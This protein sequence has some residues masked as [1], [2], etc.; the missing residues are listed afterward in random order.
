MF[1]FTHVIKR[2]YL[3]L[4]LHNGIS[5]PSWIL[6]VLTNRLDTYDPKF[7]RPAR[8]Y[9][10]QLAVRQSLLRIWRAALV[11]NKGPATTTTVS[12]NI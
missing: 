9:A 8:H 3:V 12:V 1:G 4:E 7:S 11:K 5:G 2:H 6:R 10:T